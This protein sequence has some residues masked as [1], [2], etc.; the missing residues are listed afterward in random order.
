MP[1]LFGTSGVR[2]LANEQVNPPLALR[3]G[4]GLASL[5]GNSGRVVVGRDPRTSSEML[6]SALLAGL[7]SGGCTAVRAGM[8]PTPVLAFS[9]RAWRAGA[10]VMVTASHNPPEYN[11][12]KC[13]DGEGAAFTPEREEELEGEMGRARGVEWRR[14]GRLEERDPV[15]E[16]LRW[17]LDRFPLR[18]GHRVAVDCGN[19]A[20]C[21][22]TPPLLREGGCEVLSLHGFPSGLFPGRGSEPSAE[23]LSD[24]SRVVVSSGAEV[25]FAHDGDADRIAVVDDRGR[26]A[27]PDKLLALVASHVVGRGEKVVTTV[28]ASRVVEEWVERKGGRVVRTKVGDVSVAS[29]L[30]RE[31]GR[32]GGEPSGAWILPEAH[33]AP[34]GPLAAL[35]VLR[36][37]EEEGRRLSELLDEIPSYPLLREKVPCGPGEREERMGRLRERMG[38]LRGISAVEEVDGLRI[39]FEGGSWVLVRPSGTEPCLR[40][41]CEAGTEEEARRRMREVLSLLG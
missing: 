28:D 30:R 1:R 15:G 36:V 13:W 12:L 39:S 38:E 14:V 33:L 27:P 41:T 35:L 29:A 17:V 7:L 26:F 40:V 23:S 3:L 4:L 5:L 9:V 10:G 25:G 2:G 22:V 19:G 21:R 11:G 6:E 18:E 8:V 24:L 32:F 31:G 34:D 16:Y 37:L 20:A